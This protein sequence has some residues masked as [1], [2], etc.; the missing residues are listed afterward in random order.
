MNEQASV[1]QPPPL[2]NGNVWPQKSFADVVS[3]K[4]APISY[5]QSRFK[6]VPTISFP[7]SDAHK[8]AEIH[9]RSLVDYFFRGRPSLSFIRKAFEIIGFKGSFHLGH[10][11]KKHVLIRFDLEE[12]YL[13]CWNRQTWS[14]QG[15]IMRVTKW[16]P[17]FKPNVESPVVLVWIAFEGLP[18]HLHDK[19]ALFAIAGL[20]GNPLHIDSAT[21]TL[22]R[23]LGC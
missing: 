18:I 20:I 5:T 17:E 1:A 16:S 13:R 19:R 2:P 23:P 14:I 4:E 10:L 9:K 8:L 7:E 11:E 3:N 12:D 21:A 6:G 22:A 15:N